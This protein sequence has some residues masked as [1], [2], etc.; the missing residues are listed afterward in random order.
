[1]PA[2][3]VLTTKYE[4]MY[5]SHQDLGIRWRKLAAIDKA[6]NIREL[7]ASV[8][9]RSILEVGCGDGAI[10]RELT[11]FA[12]HITGVEISHHAIAFC[13]TNGFDVQHFDGGRIPR[14]NQSVDLA[15]LSHVIEHVENP[16][17][18]LHEA[19][20]V[21]RHVFVE[22]PLEDNRGLKMDFVANDSGHINFYS[23]KTVRQLLQTCDLKI[24]AQ[25]ISHSSLVAY[26]YRLGV[27]GFAAWSVK[28]AALLFPRLAT[29]VW[30]YHYS[31]LATHCN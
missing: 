31:L 18:L 8:P 13:T 12:D 7:C 5:S 24:E 3:S 14:A 2:S 26:R 30:T 27:R 19:A 23:I 25:K 22:V 20:R 15:V 21:A 4:E 11:G 17:E 29:A 9:H 6:K 1:M 28:S 16:R 10:M